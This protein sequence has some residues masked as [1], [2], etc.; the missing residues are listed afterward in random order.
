MT[1]RSARRPTDAELGIL[2]ILW[3]R[4]PST[5]RAIQEALA[6]EDTEGGVAGASVLKLLHIMQAKGLVERDASARAHVY[7]AARDEAEV[8]RQLTEHLVA[9]AFGGSAA[10]LALRALASKPA[11]GEEL[12]EIEALIAGF[13]Q[14]EATEDGE[15]G[16]G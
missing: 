12:A 11:S 1:D 16:E 4:G 6:A 7:R 5:V 14:R 15:G 2:R 9:R 10:R 3:A 13:K 8:Q